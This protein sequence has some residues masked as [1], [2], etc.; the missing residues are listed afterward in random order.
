[1][2]KLSLWEIKSRVLKIVQLESSSSHL[3]TVC[4]SPKACPF[5]C[6]IMPLPPS[7]FGSI[8]I[9]ILQA[10]LGDTMGSAP[11][12]HNT[13]SIAILRVLNFSL[14]EGLASNL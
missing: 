2:K 5:I 14:V 6:T 8:S 10:Y 4:S 11:D 1:M 3:N 12:R 9:G 7:A 13:A